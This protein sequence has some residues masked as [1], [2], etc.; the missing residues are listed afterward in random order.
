MRSLFLKIFLW[1]WLANILVFGAL[2]V[3]FMWAE[4]GP[5]RSGFSQLFNRAMAAYG[6]E[7]VDRLESDGR[8]ALQEYVDGLQR[9]GEVQLLLFD[10]QGCEVL[11]QTAPPEMKELAVRTAREG[12]PPTPEHGRPLPPLAQVVGSSG[13]RYAVVGLGP[14]PFRLPVEPLITLAVAAAVVSYLLARYVTA[15]VRR[16]RAV[17]LRLADGDLAARV[18]ATLS[19]RHDVIG[20]LARDFD[21]M[22][23]RIESLMSAQRRLLRD[24]SHELRSP[25]ARLS[26]ALGLA[27]RRAGPETRQ[28]LER[29]ELE[30]ERLNELIGQLLTLA[31]LD[32][33]GQRADRMAIDLAELVQRIAAD[34]GFE[35]RSRGR[36][37]RVDDCQE[38]TVLGAPELLYSAIENV[39]RNAVCY[40]AEGTEV[41]ITLRRRSDGPNSWG[42][43]RIRDHGTGVPE[44]ALTEIFRPFHRVTDA[45]ERQTGGV[46]LG[47]AITQR[48]IKLHGGRVSAVNATDG[49][50]IVEI[51][52]PAVPVLRSRRPAAGNAEADSG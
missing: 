44:T 5:P 10:E 45:R 14:R 28:A 26:V 32:G 20:D 18:G 4:L 52:L 35:A 22:A 40:T 3:V 46:G 1:Y 47:L 27:A 33:S 25:L 9:A 49:G 48:A 30:A 23:E 36:R 39:V 51:Q 7:A 42:V 6:R 37:V 34:G 11:G 2:T 12:P 21:F 31:R 15:P 50:L 19:H 41:E 13:S 29:I 8:P 17:T 16:L 38:C 24:V 43:I